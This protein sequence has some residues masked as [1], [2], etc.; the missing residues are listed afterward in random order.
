MSNDRVIHD[1]LLE[2]KPEGASHDKAACSFCNVEIASEQEEDVTA[3]QKIFTQEQHEQLLASA[4]EK[5]AT[6]A[7]AKVDAEILRLNEQLEEAQAALTASSEEVE[8]LKAQIAER[9]EADRL[10]EVASKRV[11]L[12][13]A[14]ANFTDE[15]IT[16]RTE[17]WSKM[18]E[19]EF[20][21][22][23]DDL[24]AVAKAPAE[25][26][27]VPKTK[28]NGTRET[29]GDKGSEKSVVKDFFSSGAVATA[30]QL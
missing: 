7:S 2:R 3:D 19:E 14:V 5:A 11:E 28:F 10:A 23:L 21:S 1:W 15:Q 24:R 12:V 20:T 22:Y 13:R 30:A 16:E 27:N 9:E 17:R 8:A 4:V 29:A 26:E 25:E 18:S 6:E